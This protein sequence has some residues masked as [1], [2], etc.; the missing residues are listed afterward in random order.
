MSA[1]KYYNVPAKQKLAQLLD[2]MKVPTAIPA[3]L[4]HLAA[5]AATNGWQTACDTLAEIR[6]GYVHSNKKR[7]QVVLSAPN[8]ATFEAWQLS[9]WYQESHFST[10]LATRRVPE[11]AHGRMAGRG[12]DSPVGLTGLDALTFMPKSGM[13]MPILGAKAVSSRSR[14]KSLADALFTKTQQRVLR[15]LFG[16]P[17]RSFYASELI[18]DA[19]TGSG[20]AQRELAKLEGSGLISARRIGHQKHY[21]ANAASPLYSEL[22]NIVLKTVGLAEPLRDA[23][24]PLSFAIRA[25]FVYGSVAKA[26][27]QAA[28]DI[29]LMI[30]SDRLTYGEVFG[31]LDR[32][33]RAVGRKV[34]PTVYTAAEFSKRARTENAFVTRVLEQPKLW[35]IGSEDDLPVAA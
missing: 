30:I 33:T 28:S 32:V 11:P 13:M 5:F 6:H 9:L 22:R 29:D 19:G 20:A 7:R 24:K 21:Q 26:T 35:V 2:V 8:L 4:S 1:S 34:N 14:R 23:L 3:K 15:V 16:Q 25:A 17:E 27:D 18:R 31:A 10:C 12:G